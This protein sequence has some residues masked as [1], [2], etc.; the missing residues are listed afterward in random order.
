MPKY[1]YTLAD[2]E[3]AKKK[4]ISGITHDGK[5]YKVD[6]NKPADFVLETTKLIAEPG[7]HGL[8]LARTLE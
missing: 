2:P 7:V 6:L 1:V 8:R 5:A 4:G 3:K